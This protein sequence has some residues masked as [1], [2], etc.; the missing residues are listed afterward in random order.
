MN[1]VSLRLLLKLNK[2]VHSPN[3]LE[4]NLVE[5][6]GGRSANK[7]NYICKLFTAKNKNYKQ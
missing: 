5:E 2:K 4:I 7:G 6:N 3:V 1:I